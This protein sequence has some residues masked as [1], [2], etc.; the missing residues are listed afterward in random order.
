MQDAICPCKQKGLGKGRITWKEPRSHHAWSTLRQCDPLLVSQ[1][2]PSRYRT[3]AS[4]GLLCLEHPADR[5]AAP[6]Q[7]FRCVKRKTAWLNTFPWNIQFSLF[8]VRIAA[9]R[10]RRQNGIKRTDSSCRTISGDQQ[11]HKKPAPDGF[12]TGFLARQDRYPWEVLHI[13]GHPTILKAHTQR[14]RN[15]D[16]GHHS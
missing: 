16:Q 9:G 1:G 7:V 8:C 6:L 11:L 10:A 12:R 3:S 4:A 13:R 15:A 14:G 2:R 5:A